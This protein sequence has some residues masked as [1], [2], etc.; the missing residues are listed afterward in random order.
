MKELEIEF[1]N[2]LTGEEYG[3]LHEALFKD[4]QP[5]VQTN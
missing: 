4:T 1:K 2:L 3:R 5:V